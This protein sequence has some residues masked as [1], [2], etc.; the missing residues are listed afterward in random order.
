MIARS[1]VRALLAPL[2]IAACSRG[3]HDANDT[4]TW[5]T[6][7]PPG[8][9]LHLRD[10]NGSLTVRPAVGTTMEVKGS[11]HWT[12]GRADNVK[13]VAETRG[14]DVSV[15]AMFGDRGRCTPDGYRA[16][17]TG[18]HNV[19]VPAGVK[20]DASTV[21]GEVIVEGASAPVVVKTVSGSIDASTS[22]GPMTVESVNGTINARV[23]SLPADSGPLSFTTINGSVTAVLP[24]GLNATADL[25][26][27]TGSI[28]SDFPLPIEG[29]YGPR[30]A[31]GVVGAGGRALHL[32]TINGSV[33]LK[34]R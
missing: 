24:A 12:H 16:R 13:F 34:R 23:D 1:L 7:M 29:Q 14:G 21:Q 11:K 3:R 20:I 17:A 9:T 2:A 22:V 4:W 32:R 18:F 31:R 15:C 26:T 33:T 5:Q 28:T 19:F 30:H 6:D 27:I 8:T 25:E 10:V